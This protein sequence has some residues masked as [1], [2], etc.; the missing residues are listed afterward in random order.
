MRTTAGLKAEPSHISEYRCPL[1]SD[2]VHK[3][4]TARSRETRVPFYQT[5]RRHVI[6]IHNQGRK[7]LTLLLMPR[8][9]SST[10]STPSRCP[11]CFLTQTLYECLIFPTHATQA[12][13][14]LLL[15]WMRDT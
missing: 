8:I 13:D 6:L 14:L 3:M 2:A 12:A 10:G 1:V 7:N 11:P 9:A 15:C 4:E 5:T